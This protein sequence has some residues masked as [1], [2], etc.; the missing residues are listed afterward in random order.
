[1][2]SHAGA[3]T[4]PPIRHASVQ[5]VVPAAG[6][7]MRLRPLT[8]DRPKGLVRVAGE[9]LLSWVFDALLDV[10]V[11]ELV[12]IVGYRGDAIR[13]HFGSTVDG[14]PVRYVTQSDQ[15]GL[16]HALAC[17]GPVIDGDFLW[18][19]GDNICTG[20]LSA[21]RDR[22]A[23]TDTVATCLVEHVSPDR[24]REVGVFELADG[25]VVGA[26]E[27]PENPPSSLVPRGFYAFDERVV[28]ACK[29]VRPGRTGERELTAALDL[30]VRAGWSVE[31]VSLDGWCVNVN[32]PD[33]VE[34]VEAR[35]ED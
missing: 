4:C 29:L 35:L 5:G 2:R 30:L 16:A 32:D 21:V 18:M 6:Q 24:A 12:V 25:D 22:H 15:R 34:R 31:T 3:L 13:E 1:M 14:V 33:D 17:A 8:A 26:V 10:G 23:A 27:K 19:H 11:D 7:G 28:S 20:N 9:P